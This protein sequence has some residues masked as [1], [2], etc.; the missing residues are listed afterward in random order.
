MLRDENIRCN[1]LE[2]QLLLGEE[3]TATK[4]EGC[5]DGSCKT[6]RKKKQ[7]NRGDIND[8]GIKRRPFELPGDDVLGC[9]LLLAPKGISGAVL[10]AAEI[11]LP[12]PRSGAARL[13]IRSCKTRKMA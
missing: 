11:M 10:G 8:S 13:A 5:Y 12:L 6:K 1:Q 4:M 3:I 2:L 9:L 7:R